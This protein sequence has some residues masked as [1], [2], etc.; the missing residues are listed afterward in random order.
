M[1]DTRLPGGA[2]GANN[3]TYVRTN[4]GRRDQFLVGLLRAAF[5]VGQVAAPALAARA[6]EQ[7]FFRPPRR[8][9]SRVG[10]PAGGRRVPAGAP[11]GPLAVWSWGHGPAVYLLH[12][13]GGRA[14][15]LAGFVGPLVNAGF[16]VVALDAPGHGRSAGRLSSAPEFARALVSVAERCGAPHGFVA[17]SLGAAAVAIALRNGVPARRLVFIGAP[18]QPLAWVDAFARRLGLEAAVLDRM[19]KLS[20][21]RLAFDWDDLV[22]A[23]PPAVP[24][25]PLLVVHDRDDREVASDDGAAIAATWPGARLHTT[26]G[27]GHHRVL[28][29]PAVV[30]VAAAFLS[31]ERME[32]S[33]LG[34]AACVHERTPPEAGDRCEDCTLEAD[35]FAPERR[36][37][38]ACPA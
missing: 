31:G 9:P 24:A 21:R 28:R 33:P 37:L 27:L 13:W 22:V 36:R 18:L 25:P 34:Q 15:Q 4:L 35:L 29:D 19:R 30:A 8:R 23:P 38:G 20:E 3:R 7:L 1:T 6:A 12:G 16:R 17:H 2:P 32:T 11:S 26:T 10:L 5:A 14:E